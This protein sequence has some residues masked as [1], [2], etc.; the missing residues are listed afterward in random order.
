MPAVIL[1]WWPSN[2]TARDFA[3]DLIVELSHG[4]VLHNP[5]SRQDQSGRVKENYCNVTIVCDD[6][7]ARYD[8][9]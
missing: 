4:P 8:S 2:F 5:A 3:S 6:S 1:D 9:Y 7:A